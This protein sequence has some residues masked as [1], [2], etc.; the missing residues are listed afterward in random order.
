MAPRA[1]E[2][3]L[4][5]SQRTTRSTTSAQRPALKDLTNTRPGPHG[6]ET[7]PACRGLAVKLVKK[8]VD[9]SEPEDELPI[10]PLDPKDYN[11]DYKLAQLRAL[12]DRDG[13]A[14]P[15]STTKRNV[16]DRIVSF[17]L[18]NKVGDWDTDCTL[19]SYDPFADDNSDGESDIRAGSNAQSEVS[20][21][22]Q[23]GGKSPSESRD[24]DWAQLKVLRKIFYNKFN[25]AVDVKDSGLL[26]NLVECAC[27][28]GRSE[29]RAYDKK[30]AS[31]FH[32]LYTRLVDKY[33]RYVG[34]S[35]H[36]R[37]PGDMKFMLEFLKYY[38]ELKPERNSQD[39]AVFSHTYAEQQRRQASRSASAEKSL[40]EEDNDNGG[41]LNEPKKDSAAENNTRR[42]EQ[43][44]FED[45]KE[46]LGKKVIGLGND[47]AVLTSLLKFCHETR[48]TKNMGTHFTSRNAAWLKRLVQQKCAK[49]TGGT[50]RDKDFA[51]ALLYFFDTINVEVHVGDDRST[52]AHPSNI[53]PQAETVEE[54][55][56]SMSI[57]RVEAPEDVPV[58]KT[59]SPATTEIAGS[60][61][62]EVSFEGKKEYQGLITKG[63]QT[64]SKKTANS[65]REDFAKIE[66]S[67]LRKDIKQRITAHL[68]DTAFIAKLWRICYRLR[69][70]KTG[71]L[72]EFYSRD[73]EYVVGG[74]S[75][76]FHEHVETAQKRVDGDKDLI[77]ELLIA[78]DALRSEAR[79]KEHVVSGV[80]KG[81]SEKTE[82][83]RTKDEKAQEPQGVVKRKLTGDKPCEKRIKTS[84]V[85]VAKNK[86][87]ASA[88]PP[89]RPTTTPT[90]ASRKRSR[91]EDEVQ[92]RKKEHEVKKARPTIG[93]NKPTKRTRDE[94]EKERESKE[95]TAKK[96]R[97]TA[98]RIEPPNGNA[99]SM[100]QKGLF[101]SNSQVPHPPPPSAVVPAPA[102]APQPQPL[103][104]RSPTPL[105]S[106]V[107]TPYA[108]PCP[109][110]L[111]SL[112]V[113]Q[114]W[115]PPRTPLASEVVTPGASPS[116]AP[117][118]PPVVTPLA[119]PPPM[120]LIPSKKRKREDVAS[121]A[122]ASP[123]PKKSFTEYMKE[124]KAKAEKAA[125]E[126]KAVES[127]GKSA[128]GNTLGSTET[129][130][131]ASTRKTLPYPENEVDWEGG[132]IQ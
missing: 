21:D 36:H 118:A 113:I 31:D 67:V 59:K 42:Y 62:S 125:A 56:T 112:G 46:E 66:F 5:V 121:E 71:Q 110:P 124:K 24:P 72:P 1:T 93:L 32:Y 131:A 17:D 65:D 28:L 63:V 43:R 100:P 29:S 58:K 25:S 70:L 34:D 52:R 10:R 50:A 101:E 116:L 78:F 7:T 51:A 96:L 9:D 57:S 35:R 99:P 90:V 60:A 117:P 19:D 98:Q 88:L 119:L 44:D 109:F 11:K 2:G 68:H 6:D 129:V 69:P 86:S 89:S 120:L 77:V 39:F 38:Y 15:K 123:P 3:N 45:L 115:S 126:T 97:T 127:S 85:S 82:A 33:K 108:S 18:Q 12:C 14:Y 102:A 132:E 27:Q 74:F 26:I 95:P 64:S 41:V 81:S 54:R 4:A 20:E 107:L 91:G 8:K 106:E 61:R 128:A 47:V 76:K 55:T 94:G 23:K 16:I 48:P 53:A 80:E 37:I 49:H 73:P 84:G 40:A 75:Q 111:A 92:Q 114:W 122:K 130:T 83:E 30:K 105:A 103:A 22:K 79:H 104:S 87:T 13:I